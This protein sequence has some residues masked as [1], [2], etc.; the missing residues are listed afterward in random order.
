MSS[1]RWKAFL[2]AGAGLLGVTAAGALIARS[3]LPVRDDPAD[4]D[5][6][7]VSIFDGSSLR[8]TSAAFR[9]GT[10]ISIFGGTQL[11]LRRA[12]LAGG[13]GLLHVTTVFGGTDITVPDGW[14]VSI[15]GPK[16]ASGVGRELPDDASLQPGAPTLHIDARTI[17][18][19]LHVVAR[20]VLRAA[21]ETA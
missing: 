5:I 15:D 8:P 1:T 16:V 17:F 2:A 9:G 21:G 3:R 14:K 13:H 6:A 20:P 4:T 12:Q 11:D 10:V 19:G 7:L 18:G